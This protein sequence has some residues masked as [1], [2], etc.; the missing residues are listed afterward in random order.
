MPSITSTQTHNMA[1]LDRFRKTKSAV[2]PKADE[3]HDKRPVVKTASDDAKASRTPK[4]TKKPAR[5]EEAVSKETVV[6]KVSGGLDLADRLLLKPHVS[7]KAARL[8]D[9]GIYVF[10]VRLDAEKVAVRKAVE[11]L[12][13]VKV[14]KV[15]I[16]RGIGKPIRRGRAMSRRANWK[17]A[18]VEVKK[19]QTIDLYEGV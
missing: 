11:S 4:P 1:I 14:E 9:K 8:A 12:Y 6:G 19:G 10:D 18:L 15:R 7:E 5:K 13:N 3:G 17:K 16:V 2:K